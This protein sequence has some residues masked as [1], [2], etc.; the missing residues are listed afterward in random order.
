MVG[1]KPRIGDDGTGKKAKSRP[2]KSL[3]RHWF[4][5]KDMVLNYGGY[6]GDMGDVM[7]WEHT[8]Y[9]E[10]NEVLIAN[11][12]GVKINFKNLVKDVV[13]KI[14]FDTEGASIVPEGAHIELM[15]LCGGAPHIIHNGKELR[16]MWVKGDEVQIRTSNFYVK[17]L[18]VVSEN[19][20]KPI[21]SSRGKMPMLEDDYMI[22]LDDDVDIDSFQLLRKTK[23]KPKAKTIPDPIENPDDDPIPKLKPSTLP[24]EELD[25]LPPTYDSDKELLYDFDEEYM[26]EIGVNLFDDM[27]DE[28]GDGSEDG[29]DDGVGD[30]QFEKN[31]QLD[32][33][34]LIPEEGYYST[35]SS[36]DGDDLPATEELAKGEE[37]DGVDGYTDNI[38][39]WEENELFQDLPDVQYKELLVGMQWP[40]IY[41]A[42]EY[43]RKFAIIRKFEFNYVKNESYRMRMKCTNENCKWLAFVLRLIDGH[44]M[45]LKGHHFEHSCEGTLGAKNKM[46]HALWVEDQVEELVRDVKTISPKQLKRRIKKKFG[47]D[48][49]YCTAWN[50]KTI[51]IERIEG[52]YDKGPILG[53]DGCFLKGKYGGVV[54]SVL[55][56]DA[57]NGLFPIGVYFCRCECTNTWKAFLTKSKS[58]LEEHPSKL[59][60]I[61][62]RQKGLIESV[63]TV[64]THSNHR[65]CF[66]HMFKNM[67]K[68][69]K[70][71]HLEMLAWGAAKSFK[72]VEKNAFLDKM[73]QDNPATIEYLER[74]HMKYG[75][76]DKPLDKAIERLNLML[77]KLMYE[78]RTK[79]WVWVHSGLISRALAHIE[80][81]KKHY[82][83][84]DYEGEDDHEFTAIGAS[85]LVPMRLPWEGCGKYGMYGHNKKTCKGPP[86]PPPIPRTNRAVRVDTP[87]TLANN[88]RDMGFDAPSNTVRSTYIPNRGGRPRGTRPRPQAVFV[89]G[90]TQPN[91]FGVTT[92]SSGQRGKG[93]SSQRGRGKVSQARVPPLESQGRRRGI[94]SNTRGRGRT[95]TKEAPQ[96]I[97]IHQATN[98]PRGRVNG[99]TPSQQR[100][101]DD[102]LTNNPTLNQ[103]QPL[104]QVSQTGSAANPPPKSSTSATNPPPMPSRN[105][106]N[107]YLKT[108]NQTMRPWRN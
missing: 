30:I 28:V 71:K 13:N 43:F 48:I 89:P 21:G 84:Y 107:P 53:L 35:H 40:T 5:M 12:D 69:H 63:S 33:D 3:K 16:D 67:K 18:S 95:S 25:E 52:S 8:D 77:M 96:G 17:V 37:F 55:S 94:T 1:K 76:R 41:D 31:A 100:F 46:A 54:L 81:L 4:D 49:S 56:L 90:N 9:K 36:Q 60:F 59:T 106:E 20:E 75:I 78:R 11:V 22:I 24:E 70:G 10:G 66:R 26:N 2:I 47:I 79:A 45:E 74:S 14:N 86:A 68:Y 61:Y 27:E 32:V 44:T 102:W 83:D 62:D 105:A 91:E 108:F 51:C 50:A 92:Q 34:N 88:R 39:E 64:F 23:P 29:G 19:I 93:K 103:T 7:E 98:R 15:C 42:R 65:F 85:A 6:W 82:G 72:K 101:L 57:N 58:F 80:I 99:L 38:F 87:S 73:Q 97:G 104:T